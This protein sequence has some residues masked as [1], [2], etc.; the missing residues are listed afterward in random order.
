MECK[1]RDNL[2]DE[3]QRSLDALSASIHPVLGIY[4]DAGFGTKFAV[5]DE[6]NATYRSARRAWI[7]HITE[8]RCCREDQLADH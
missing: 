6:A 7:I 2:W 4:A 3:Y 8:H 5:S 1:E